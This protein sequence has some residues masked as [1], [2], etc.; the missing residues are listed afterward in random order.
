[1][2]PNQISSVNLPSMDW[3][4]NLAETLEEYGV[5]ESDVF[6]I[7]PGVLNFIRY[8]M[9]DIEEL[10]KEVIDLRETTEQQAQDL[11]RI[12]AQRISLLLKVQR[13]TGEEHVQDIDL[14]QTS[15]RVIKMH[16]DE[17][18]GIQRTDPPAEG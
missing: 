8:L 9:H 10:E 7:N 5:E 3:V 13:L 11:K 14:S 4:K 17:T 15:L 18:S 6:G 2:D 1:M 12:R 16:H